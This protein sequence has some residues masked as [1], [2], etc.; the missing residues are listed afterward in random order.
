MAA[1]RAV[2]AA[3][4]IGLGLLGAGLGGIAHVGGTVA[5]ADR[6]ASERSVRAHLAGR[7]CHR[8]PARPAADPQREL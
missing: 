2:L 7:D 8:P 6:V 4:L 1:M 3:G 5:T